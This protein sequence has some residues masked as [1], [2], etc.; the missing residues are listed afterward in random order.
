MHKSFRKVFH[1]ET[2]ECWKKLNFYV[3]IK[4]KKKQNY[5]KNV[6]LTQNEAKQVT[7]LTF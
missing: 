1:V 2:F 6:D 5:D 3:I 4:D 7:P